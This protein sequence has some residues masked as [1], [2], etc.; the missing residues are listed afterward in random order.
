MKKRIGI[1]GFGRIGRNAARIILDRSDCE[2]IAINSGSDKSSHEYLLA[3]DSVYGSFAKSLEGVSVFQEKDPADIPWRNIDVVLEC[4]GKFTT[5]ETASLHKAEHVI[6]SAPARDDTPTF[7]FGVNHTAYAGQKV[8]SNSS[9]TTNCVATVLK[10]MDDSFGVIRGS[11]TTVHASTDSQNLLDNSIK[12]G[13]RDRRSAMVNMIPATS[14]SARDVAKLFPHLK[15]VLQCRAIRVPLPTVSLIELVIEVKK[16]TS[17][18][19]VNG[20]FV[21]AQNTTHKGILSVATEELVSTDYI[22]NP[23]SSIVDP[24]LT[25]VVGNSLIHVTAWYDNEWGY[26]NRLVEMALHSLK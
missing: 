23:H 18:E 21:S 22:G 6:I 4:T 19:D 24:F 10:V 1:N 20:A 25:D 9:C 13:I 7:V 3:H 16:N 8:I 11:M 26:A 14:G 15:G 12:K 5:T 2:L 17:V